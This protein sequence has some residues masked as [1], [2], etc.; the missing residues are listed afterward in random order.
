MVAVPKNTVLE[1]VGSQKGWL[2]VS[3]Q[4]KIAYVDNAFVKMLP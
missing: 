4:G 3:Y 2:K 1:V